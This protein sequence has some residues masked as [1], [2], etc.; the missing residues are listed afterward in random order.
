MSVISTIL[1]GIIGFFLKTF[2][3]QFGFRSED[4]KN[5]KETYESIIGIW[6]AIRNH[7]F[8]GDFTNKW[9]ELDKIYGDS[10]L[11]IGKAYLFSDQQNLI[12]EIN[13]FNEKLYRQDWHKLTLEEINNL[14]ENLKREALPLISR[15]RRDID[16][17]KQISL[18]DFWRMV[19]S[20]HSNK[21]A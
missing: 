14:L 11:I 4:I 17:S 13:D 5:K 12:D 20:N 6:V 9:L 19:F 15:M 10:Q 18:R 16:A 1:G 7:I 3:V 2:I 21:F 8:H